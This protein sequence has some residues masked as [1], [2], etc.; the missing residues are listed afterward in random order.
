[1]IEMN[2]TTTDSAGEWIFNPIVLLD[3]SK[4]EL[5]LKGNPDLLSNVQQGIDQGWISIV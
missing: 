1:M 2:Y 4:L 5:I 3:D